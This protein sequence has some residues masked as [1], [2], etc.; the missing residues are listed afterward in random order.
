MASN[1]ALFK[2]IYRSSWALVVGINDYKSAP[3]LGYACQDAEAIAELLKSQLR[4]PE[5]NV[6]V[7]LD[8]D[9]SREGIMSSFLRLSGN[10]V[11]PDDRIVFFFAGHGTTRIGQVV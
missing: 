3:P 1:T 11:D 9:A 4:F 5:E 6:D 8:A 2:P 10:D 7:L